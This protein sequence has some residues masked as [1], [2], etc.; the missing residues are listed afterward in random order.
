MK[1]SVKR[2]TNREISLSESGDWFIRVYSSMG[3]GTDSV[4]YSCS[5]VISNLE[6]MEEMQIW[7]YTL[8]LWLYS[9]GENVVDWRSN[10]V[11]MP[12]SFYSLK[13][14]SVREGRNAWSWQTA[15]VCRSTIV[16]KKTRGNDARREE[17]RKYAFWEMTHPFFWC[18]TWSDVWQLIQLW[19]E[20][21][22]FNSCRDLLGL[23][24]QTCA[25]LMLIKA[26]RCRWQSS[27]VFSLLPV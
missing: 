13:V 5:V 22:G 7:D 4:F 26:H 15:I 27:S 19:S 23:D 16:L 21:V 14:L 9:G 18:V 10:I 1:W 11:M 6:I 12:L 2:S 25:V 3:D 17:T 24:L 8:S 20:T